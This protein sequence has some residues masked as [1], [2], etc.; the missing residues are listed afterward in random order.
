MIKKAEKKITEEVKNKESV[1]KEN[2][3]TEK[4]KVI[5]EAKIISAVNPHIT[6]KATFLSE[7]G[8]YVFKISQNFNKIMVKEAIKKQFNVNPTKVSIINTPSKT[9]VLKRRYAEKPGYK[10]AVVYLK[11]GEKIS[12]A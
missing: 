4:K 8:A 9:I 11:K 5:K 7:K 10:K 6:E 1:K 12:L 2:K 3:K